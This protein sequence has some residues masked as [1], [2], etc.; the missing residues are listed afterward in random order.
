MFS[1]GSKQ[2]TNGKL[3]YGTPYLVFQRVYVKEVGLLETIMFL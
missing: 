2:Y 3:E 1:N